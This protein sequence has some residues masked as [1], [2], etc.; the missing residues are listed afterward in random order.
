M[1]KVIIFITAAVLVLLSACGKKEPVTQTQTFTKPDQQEAETVSQQ[2]SIESEGLNLQLLPAYFPQTLPAGFGCLRTVFYPADSSDNE[3]GHDK[4]RLSMTGSPYEMEQINLAFAAAGWQ[5]S[6]NM[7]YASDDYD[8]LATDDWYRGYWRRGNSVAILSNYA[9][10]GQTAIFNI[11]VVAEAKETPAKYVSDRF[12][13][14]D[15][16]CF[17]APNPMVIDNKSN[18]I[19]NCTEPEKYNW[20]DAYS[21]CGVV[22]EDLDAYVTALT[23][24]GYKMS[25]DAVDSDYGRYITMNGT[26]ADGYGLKIVFLEYEQTLTIQYSNNFSAFEAV[27]KDSAQNS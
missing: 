20:A 27:A 7:Y 11:D 26:G 9:L 25:Y 21:Y 1:K 13:L 17:T 6:G 19:E 24:A 10:Q 18:Y 15:G 2:G 8:G 3:F 5:G 23:E 22:F 14:F 4:V 16:L 12:P